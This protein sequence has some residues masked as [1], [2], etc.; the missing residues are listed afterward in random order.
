MILVTG[1]TGL[2]GCHLLFLLVNNNKK[3]LALKRK[4]SNLENVK[5]VFSSYSKNHKELFDFI[6]EHKPDIVDNLYLIMK[7][8]LIK[9]GW[10][11]GSENK[12]YIR[13]FYSKNN[14]FC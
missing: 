9:R 4:S 2:V 1:G 8:E 5:K 13:F 7:D 3:V 11:L 12:Y 6:F 10:L 14:P